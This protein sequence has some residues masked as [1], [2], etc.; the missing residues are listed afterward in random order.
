[1]AIDTR[2][3]A[4]RRCHMISIRRHTRDDAVIINITIIPEHK[5]IAATAGLKASPAGRIHKVHKLRRIRAYDFNFTQRRGIENA[6]TIACC[7]AFSCNSLMNIL[8]V[9]REIPS[10]PPMPDRFIN[11]PIRLSPSIYG[12][13]ANRVEELIITIANKG[14]ECCWR[15]RWAE[16]G[17]A[18]FLNRF[19]YG[20]GGNFK[21]VKVRCLTLICRHTIGGIAFNVFD[22]LKTFLNGELDVLF[23][24]II[25]KIDKGFLLGRRNVTWQFTQNDTRSKIG[26][27]GLE[28]LSSAAG[29]VPCG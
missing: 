2:S 8:T 29:L 12:C 18:H 27:V 1:M 21:R 4:R 22:R 25:L 11:R 24:H 9:L 5:S 13:F 7:F 20:F 26:F 6:E 19:A 10:A 23:R 3:S 28:S 15:I 17:Q 14:S 16:G